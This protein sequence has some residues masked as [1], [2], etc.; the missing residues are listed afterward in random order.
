MCVC[1][2][3]DCTDLAYFTLLLSRIDCHGHMCA[4]RERGEGALWTRAADE[5]CLSQRTVVTMLQRRTRRRQQK[6]VACCTA[7]KLLRYCM[8]SLVL[9][10]PAWILY[11]Y[12]G[13]ISTATTG[14]AHRDAAIQGNLRTFVPTRTD[15]APVPWTSSSTEPSAAGDTPLPV[16]AAPTP[17]AAS[18]SDGSAV[19][20]AD[21][22]QRAEQPLVVPDAAPAP[23]PQVFPV[24][25]QMEVPAAVD[26]ASR[27]VVADKSWAAEPLE[28][29][30]SQYVRILEDYPQHIREMVL[31]MPPHRFKEIRR[32]AGRVGAV[33]ATH[34]C[35]TPNDVCDVVSQLACTTTV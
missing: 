9:V 11:A 33:T 6:P 22:G 3:Q 8:F 15:T 2:A 20:P 27:H 26:A 28:Q 21:V 16:P 4:A 31:A 7:S 5:A 32:G 17:A 35:C 14:V 25:S 19:P 29:L 12:S 18:A 10:V 30:H 1:V 24:D 34:V 13:P 23:A